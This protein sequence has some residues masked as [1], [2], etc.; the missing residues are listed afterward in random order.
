MDDI[1]KR[2]KLPLLVGGSGFYLY[3]LLFP[4]QE[5]KSTPSMFDHEKL[6]S[7][8]DLYSIDPERASTIHKNDA[9]RI[10]QAFRT[11]F[12]TGVLPS[13]AVPVYD[14]FASY[15]I[16]FLERERQ[17]LYQRI[18]IRLQAMIKQGWIDEVNAVRGSTWE[19]FLSEKKLIGYNELLEFIRQ[20]RQN[21]S[22]VLETIH[23]RTCRY[24]KRQMT[25]WRFLQKKI[26]GACVSEDQ[27][28][29]VLNFSE[30]TEAEHIRS[31]MQRVR[32]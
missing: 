11:F 9:Y 22:D 30:K 20:G 26:D 6:Y 7:W 1:W 17:E 4:I 10:K 14:P 29:I 32:T 15:T 16:I 25:F 19:Q 13:I 24:A 8:D 21:L 12:R 2:G 28:Q 18:S 31:L 5:T 27:N 3:S 23:Q